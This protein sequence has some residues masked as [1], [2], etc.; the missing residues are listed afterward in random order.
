MLSQ[1]NSK[2]SSQ[3]ELE[4]NSLNYFHA[5]V[6]FEADRLTRALDLHINKCLASYGSD[7]GF[8]IRR[9]TSIKLAIYQSALAN[10]HNI[11]TN[12]TAAWSI[13]QG[14]ELERVIFAERQ[15]LVIDTESVAVYQ[16]FWL[17]FTERY[18]SLQQVDIF[19]KFLFREL[20]SFSDPF[21]QLRFEL[22]PFVGTMA[23]RSRATCKSPFLHAHEVVAIDVHD[24]N[25]PEECQFL[26]D[27]FPTRWF[28]TQAF[29]CTRAIDFFEKCKRNS[30]SINSFC[31]N[32]TKNDSIHAIRRWPLDAEPQN[33]ERLEIRLSFKSI[34]INFFLSLD[35]ITSLDLTGS[36]IVNLFNNSFASVKTTL[37]ELRLFAVPLELVEKDCLCDMI[38]LEYLAIDVAKLARLQLR[39]LPQL[40]LLEFDSF[41]SLATCFIQ[42]DCKPIVS[43]RNFLFPN[44]IL[45]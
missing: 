38:R 42:I 26:I 6:N 33:I 2:T 19:S 41:S 40:Q 20:F 28:I 37:K 35:S 16:N 5:M 39:R 34:P 29:K 1:N 17:L 25:I 15:Y 44:I 45:E 21:A 18:L 14:E 8:L 24:L 11:R 9:G 10:H 27:W 43:F 30:V 3:M 32:V 22:S 31:A 7:G 13:L 4:N 12:A 36:S 23:E